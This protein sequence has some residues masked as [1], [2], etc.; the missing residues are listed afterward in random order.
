MVKSLKNILKKLNYLIQKYFKLIKKIIKKNKKIIE[1]M[2]IDHILSRNHNIKNFSILEIGS[3]KGEIFNI[4]SENLFNQK[5]I[6][7]CIEPNPKSFKTLKKNYK[8]KYRF[9][10]TAKF[11]NFA[12][13][14]SGGKIKFYSPSK[15]TALFTM[16]YENLNSFNL[17]NETIKEVVIDSYS[18]KQLIIRNYIS[19]EYDLIKLDTEGMDYEIA[20]QII[21]CNIKFK[22][23]MLE[24]NFRDLEKLE[25]I[26]TYLENY[27]MYLYIRD[28]LKTI[29]IIKLNS[30]KNIYET[31]DFYQ[32]KFKN[33]L[34]ANLIFLEPF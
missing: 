25:K 24:V 12:V 22:N 11:Y 21:D 23:L 31:Y 29:E 32:K 10:I 27:Q 28:G 30:S 15:S 26:Y 3:H 6:I 19:Y 17:E 1:H 13:S 33:S 18:I 5:F 34:A 9:F 7:D 4:L 8:K 2:E 16:I 14:S 20:Q